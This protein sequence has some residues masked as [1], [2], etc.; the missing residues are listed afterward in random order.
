MGSKR[1][2]RETSSRFVA[3]SDRCGVS[4][5][6]I[7]KTLD[8]RISRDSLQGPAQAFKKIYMIAQKVLSAI[9]PTS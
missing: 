3:V 7:R 4:G 6:D 2:K 9:N 8:S 5:K 1:I